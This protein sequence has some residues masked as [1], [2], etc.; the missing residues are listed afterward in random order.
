VVLMRFSD[1]RR[2]RLVLADA[3]EQRCALAQTRVS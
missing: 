1:L 3:S 2:P